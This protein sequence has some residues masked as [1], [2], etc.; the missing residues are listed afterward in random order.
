MPQM[1]RQIDE[2]VDRTFKSRVP[3]ENVSEIPLIMSEITHLSEGDMVQKLELAEVDKLHGTFPCHA[4][5][6]R[7]RIH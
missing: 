1:R 5:R 7:S 2:Y 3:E 6:P 4:E